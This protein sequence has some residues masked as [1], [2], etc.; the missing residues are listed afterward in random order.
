MITAA[1][2]SF[3][4]TSSVPFRIHKLR[5]IPAREETTGRQA[6]LIGASRQFFNRIVLEMA[7][8]GGAV[9]KPIIPAR[10]GMAN[11]ASANPKADRSKVATETMDI[12]RIVDGSK[13]I[14]PLLTIGNPQLSYD[15]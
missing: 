10:K 11:T 9:F 1:K 14:C 15:V 7:M 4:G 3:M 8:R 6:L 12:T 13:F 2:K 5:G